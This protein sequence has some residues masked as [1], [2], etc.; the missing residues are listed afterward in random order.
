[1]KKL[2]AAAS[3]LLHVQ[4]ASSHEIGHEHE[5]VDGGWNSEAG[6]VSGDV[7]TGLIARH[8][9]ENGSLNTLGE[10]AAIHLNDTHPA[11][12]V[13]SFVEESLQMSL[14]RFSLEQ[15]RPVLQKMALGRRRSS[16]AILVRSLRSNA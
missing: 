13:V 3:I 16:C 4:V 7:D 12:A 5:H 9:D 11:L 10:K 14:Y 2:L 8:I 15:G 1:M 6:F